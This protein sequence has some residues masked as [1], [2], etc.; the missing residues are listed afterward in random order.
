MQLGVTT[1]WVLGALILLPFILWIERR[2]WSGLVPWRRYAVLGCRMAEVLL[3]I[4]AVA[5]L[6][7]ERAREEV[8]VLFAIDASRSVPEAERQTALA[9]VTAA[10]DAMRPDDRAGLLVF[11]RGPLIE[12]V[13]QARL[14]V[15]RLESQPDSNFT[16]LASLLRLSVGLYPEG[17]RRRLVIFSDG[18]ENRGSALEAVR[19][20]QSG[21]IQVDVFPIEVP[22]RN[23]VSLTRLDLPGRVEKDEPF[24]LR[25]QALATEAG[26]ATLRF[27]RDGAVLG[28]QQVHL[29]AGI[30]PFSTTFTEE[31]PGFHTYEAVIEAPGDGEPENNLAGAF[32]QVAGPSRVLLVGSPE[33][34][35]ALTNALSLSKLQFDTAASLP[36]SLAAL[37]PYD[38]VFLNNVSA[39]EFGTEQIEGLERYARDLGGGLGMIGGENS[40]GPGGWIGTGVERALPVRMELKSKEQFPSLALTMVIDKSGSMGGISG[41]SKMDMANRAASEAVN[42]LGAKDLVGVVAFD[43]AGKWVQELAP[44]KD[45]AAIIRNILSIAPGGGTDAYQGALLAVDALSRANAKLKHIIL[46]TDGQTPPADFPGLLGRMAAAR[47]TLSTVGIGT[48]A[49]NAFLEQLAKQAGGRFYACPDPSRV[50]RIFV[51]ETILVQ[52]SYIM[53]ES[54][55]PAIAAS[56]PILARSGI[57]SAPNI[58]GWVVTEPRERSETILKIKNDPLLSTWQYGLGKSVAF[59]S[60]AKSRWARNWVGWGGFQPFW[61]RVIRWSL[62]NVASTDLHPQVA[63]DRGRGKLRVEAAS[64][65]GERL[66]FLNLKARL[67]RPDMSVEELELRQTSIGGYE[68]DFEAEAP[69]AYLAGIFDDK[70]RQGSAGGM[71]AFSPEF[72]DFKSNDY[73]LH[74]LARQTGGKVEPKID[75]IFRREGEPVRAPKEI[76]FSLLLAALGLL[77]LE[78]GLRRLHFDEEQLAWARATAARLVPFRLSPAGAGAAAGRGMPEGLKA[79]SQSVKARLNKTVSPT[80]DLSAFESTMDSAAATTIETLASESAASKSVERES[81]PVASSSETDTFSKLRA[82]RESRSQ[83]TPL[84]PLPVSKAGEAPRSEPRKTD[85]PPGAA[86][87]DPAG[88]TSRLLERKRQRRNQPD[89]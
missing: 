27:F 83:P 63:F 30:N 39:T 56:H 42:L 47:I 50:P 68:A 88:A 70:G 12:S 23:E 67:I 14:K 58:E 89:S 41:A 60:D 69:G 36:S 78:V 87:T 44:V 86:S 82:R 73:L 28:R 22:R 6:R 17:M 19:M 37:Q 15:A 40:F 34:N 10:T 65:A 64:G 46:I 29:D 48:D 32:T 35:A 74:E 8:C 45:R 33:D 71:V 52:R 81:R 77:L 54:A 5:G 66:N 3:L 75:E 18:N 51:R 84:G 26:E 49:D 25:V 21:G 20:L 16:D 79:R 13:P 62:R 38:A 53:E 72:K 80:A 55:T 61:D 9:K 24:E 85:S 1:P 2:A 76:T 4:L 7:W 11:G 31:N 57:D 59:T 43:S